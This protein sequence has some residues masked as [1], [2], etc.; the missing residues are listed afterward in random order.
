MTLSKRIRHP[1]RSRRGR[2]FVALVGIL[3]LFHN[4]DA[5]RQPSNDET[6]S[7]SCQRLDE[8]VIDCFQERY[9]VVSSLSRRWLKAE[10]CRALP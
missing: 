10:T 3:A 2:T 6:T 7:A 1:A 9:D 4:A 5:D 8:P